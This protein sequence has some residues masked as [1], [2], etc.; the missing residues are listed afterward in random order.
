M[1]PVIDVSLDA[2]PERRWEMLAPFAPEIRALYTEYLLDL[3]PLVESLRAE[4]AS[5]EALLG[6][7]TWSELQGLAK[8]LEMPF[9]DVLL[10]NLY[11]DAL[12]HLW[13]CTAF[14]VDAPGGPIHGRNLDWFSETGALGTSTAQFRFVRGGVERYRTVGWPGYLG[15]LSGVAPGRFA[16]TLN[17]VASDDAAE[18]FAPVSFL[19]RRTLATAPT[20]DDAVR[21]LAETPVSS[22][23]LLLISGTKP[24]EMAVVERTPTRSAIRRPKD[25]LIVVTNDYR[26]LAVNDESTA[27]SPAESPAEPPAESIGEQSDETDLF[28]SS[29]GRFDRCSLLADRAR[30]ESPEEAI[31]IL[32]DSNVQML[33]TAQHMAFQAATGQAVVLIP[34]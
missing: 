34:E 11:Y 31:R 4:A 20:F 17:T 18:L 21:I 3:A 8:V 9:E 14:A 25:G 1:I 6:E 24:G 23:S 28:S 22:D 16:I 27:E 19:I 2:P 30:P 32:Q 29:C 15:C 10:G 7:E 13:G 33:I 12:K 5:I 26:S